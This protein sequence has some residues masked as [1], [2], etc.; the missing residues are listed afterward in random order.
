MSKLIGTNPNQVPSNADLGSAAFM[1]KKEFLL[2]KGSSLSAI[3]VVVPK[4]AVDVFVYDTSKDSDG[5]AWRKRCQHLSWYNERLNTT[6]RGSRKEFPAVAVIVAE[7]DT[8]TIYDADDSSMPMWM[9][10][11][12]T[13]GNMMGGST[14]LNAVEMLNSNLVVGA[15][16]YAM[17]IDFIKDYGSDWYTN[18]LYEYKGNIEQRNDT[19]GFRLIESYGI[20]NSTVNDVAMTVLPNAPI[21]SAT[22]LPVPTIVVATDGGT[23]IIKN[24][25]TV[26]D[27][28]DALTGREVTN[29]IIRGNDVTHWN[30]PNGTVQ[31]FFDA[32]SLTSDNT[33]DCKYNYS[34][35]GGG[36]GTENITAM[37]LE[38]LDSNRHLANGKTYKDIHVANSDGVSKI[39]DG[40]DREFSTNT[41]SIFDS[42]VAYMTSAYNTGWMNGDIKLATLSDTDDTDATDANIVTVASFTAGTGGTV[43]TS[44]SQ[45]TITQTSGSNG[46]AVSP[47]FSTELGKK[48]MFTAEG[49]SSSG[50][51]GF[52]AEVRGPE[53]VNSLFTGTSYITFDGTGGGLYVELYCMSGVGGSVTYD[54]ILV[55]EIESDRSVNGGAGVGANGLQVFGTVAKTPV[56]TGADLVAYSGFT[57]SNYLRQPYTTAMNFGTGNICVNIWAKHIHSGGN[58]AYY[59]FDKADTDGTNRCGAYYIPSSSVIDFYTPTGTARASNVSLNNWSMITFIRS[60]T[61][62][63][64]YVNGV[65]GGTQTGVS[66]NLTSNDE[67]GTFNI[68]VRFNATEPWSIGDLSLARV[69]ATAPS[70]EQI[71]KIYEDEKVLFQENAQA[72][73]YGSSDAVTA[74]AYDD[75]T[76]LLHVGTSAGRSVFQ[77][78]RRVDNTTDAVGAAISA[79]NGLVAED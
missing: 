61:T 56:A 48:Y 60:G 51:A 40:Y 34:Y 6:T 39:H 32:L 36:G 55:Q 78:L 27:I 38:T 1:D 46:R 54:N 29:V 75:T 28:N 11:N 15:T 71:K 68:G 5:G 45:L 7:S 33:S 24:D 25:G 13:S 58:I 31:Q 41:F 16:G 70:P 17:Q 9:I 63:Y 23:S 4:S 20:I 43:S 66:E 53:I 22:G 8:V 59:F 10:F 65:L 14:S 2:S 50:G 18:Q 3:D 73:L 52:R 69:S 62:S 67:T 35:G 21:D 30:V 74:L 49:V 12:T 44:G 47:T 64:V 37:L 26:V 79:S 77:G 72:T 19:L 42:S 76:E 57:T